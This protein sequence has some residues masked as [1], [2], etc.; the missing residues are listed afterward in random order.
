[1]FRT[2]QRTWDANHS[3]ALILGMGP[4]QVELTDRNNFQPELVQQIRE[5][6]CWCIAL[7]LLE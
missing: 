2:L 7:I 5:V 4:V 6:R 1:M 3:T